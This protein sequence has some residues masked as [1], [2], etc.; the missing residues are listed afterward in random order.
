VRYYLPW[1]SDY[2]QPWEWDLGVWHQATMGVELVTDA[3]E[4]F[5][6]IWSQYDEWGFGVDL[7]DVPISTYLIREAADS[8]VD[9]SERAVWSS[10]VGRPIQVSFIWNDF[11]T[12]RP[13]CPEAVKIASDAAAAWIITAGWERR[14]SRLSIQLGMDDLMVIFDEKFAEALGLFDAY[15]GREQSARPGGDG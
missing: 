4:T 8:W 13:P 3:N 9:A 5:S 10:I 14:E 11:G 6:A 15:R 2:Q 12:T 7:Y 1:I